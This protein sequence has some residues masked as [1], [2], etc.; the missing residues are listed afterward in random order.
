MGAAL[1]GKEFLLLFQEGLEVEI[2]DLID[3]VINL[4]AVLNRGADRLMKGRG[5]INANPPVAKAGM[6]RESGMLWSGLATT[7]G[8]AAGAVLEHQRAAEQ[9]FLGEELD[10]TGACVALLG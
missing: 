10:G 8:L 9:G 1:A 6:K 3:Q 2:R 7:V 5:N 4:M